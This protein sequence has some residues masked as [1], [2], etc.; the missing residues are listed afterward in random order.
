[1]EDFTKKPEIIFISYDGII[2]CAEPFILKQIL[3]FYRKNFEKFINLS[4]IDKLDDLNLLTFC[5]K[6]QNKNIFESLALKHF[7]YNKSYMT[8]YNKFEDMYLQ[9][10]LLAIGRAITFLLSQKFTE[11]IYIY[12]KNYDKRIHADIQL[13]YK[14]MNKVNYVTGP[15]ED[16]F[17]QLNGIT[18]YIFADIL[19]ITSLLLYKEKCKYT[20]ILVA[21]YGY[22]YCIRDNNNGIISL[23]MDLEKIS[24]DLIFKFATFMPVDFTNDY[25]TMFNNKK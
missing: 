11:K 7:D 6:R 24:Q 15:L 12:S 25:F 19:D 8:M 3:K 23:R 2:K 16:V 5:V 1:M 20:N 9:S 22:N 18:T 13:N 21:N 10:D 4:L 14:D 17:N